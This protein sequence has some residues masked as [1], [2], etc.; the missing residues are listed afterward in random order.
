MTSEI[1]YRFDKDISIPAWIDLFKAAEYNPW[2][3]ERNAEAALDYAHLVVTAWRGGVAVGTLVVWS[4]G[5]NFAFIDEVVVHPDYRRRGIGTSLVQRSLERLEPLGLHCVQLF[6]IPGREPFFAR[7][8]FVV[9]P[10]AT[11]MDLAR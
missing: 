1:S 8:G 11:V 3:T 2:W 9:Q 5:V 10:N 7:L 6:P 4:D